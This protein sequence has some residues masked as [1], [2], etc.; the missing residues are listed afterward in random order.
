MAGQRAL[1][2]SFLCPP[3]DGIWGIVRRRATEE[4]I[5]YRT[6]ASTCIMHEHTQTHTS[7]LIDIPAA[8]HA[9]LILPS[10]PTLSIQGS[11]PRANPRVTHGTEMLIV[12]QCLPLLTNV[13]EDHG[14]I[15]EIP[16]LSTQ[17]CS[18]LRIALNTSSLSGVGCTSV[19]HKTAFVHMRPS[20]QSPSPQNKTN[21]Q[22]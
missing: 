20:A 18:E 9:Y 4:S 12:R 22:E 11:L 14:R 7:N 21:P 17:F 15:R 2:S 10:T 8:P 6:L 19:L 1:G 5:Q 3:S 16:I 13:P